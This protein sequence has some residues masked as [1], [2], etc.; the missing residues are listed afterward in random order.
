LGIEDKVVLL[1]YRK[2][3]DKVM[4]I[5]DVFFLPSKQEGLCLSIIEALNFGL[6][7]ITS[8]VRGCQDLVEDGKNGFIAEKDDYNKFAELISKLM[9]DKNLKTKMG[10][11]SRALAPIYSIENV[12]KELEEVYKSVK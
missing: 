6:P 12:K 7:I 5:A 1:G 10:E 11:K 3:I 8:N 9:N 4:Q 2:D